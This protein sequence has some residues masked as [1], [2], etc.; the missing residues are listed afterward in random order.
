MNEKIRELLMYSK[1]TTIDEVKDKSRFNLQERILL[2]NIL[3]NIPQDISIPFIKGGKKQVQRLLII[4]EIYDGE[5]RRYVLDPTLDSAAWAGYRLINEDMPR[6][7]DELYKKTS[8]LYQSIG[9]SI[10]FDTFNSYM[11]TDLSSFRNRVS[12]PRDYSTLAILNGFHSGD[13]KIPMDALIDRAKHK[14][15]KVL[16]TISGY[17]LKNK[18]SDLHRIQKIPDLR[19]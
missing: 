15:E 12:T 10:T 1:K 6:R 7:F 11:D 5:L 13:E 8:L 14:L 16:D 17:K 18:P 3:S 4:D 2:D 9:D 19:Y